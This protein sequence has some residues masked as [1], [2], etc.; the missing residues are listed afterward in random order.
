MRRRPNSRV[1]AEPRCTD[2]GTGTAQTWIIWIVSVRRT[3]NKPPCPSEGSHQDEDHQE[4]CTV[5]GV[6]HLSRRTV[7]WCEGVSVMR[8]TR[9]VPV[10][11]RV[12]SALNS[13]SVAR[14]NAREP[15]KPIDHNITHPS[16]FGKFARTGTHRASCGSHS[17]CRKVSSTQPKLS[18][19]TVRT[20]CWPVH[21]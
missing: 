21:I 16:R 18:C 19:I 7:G 8:R 2:S 10:A 9:G 1:V 12:R 4:E 17:G 6:D 14:T 3:A 13:L 5:T 20:R 11:Q 15:P